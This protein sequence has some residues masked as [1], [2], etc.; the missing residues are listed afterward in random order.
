MPMKGSGKATEFREIDRRDD[1][2]GWI[3]FP[4]ETMQRA[5]HAFAIDGDVWV[6]DP[7]DVE[8]LD[9]LLAEF[10][11]VAGV[12]ILL[13]RHKRDAATVANRHGVA[14]HVPDWMD[15]VVDEID[16]P[17]ERIH[18][19][20][21]D[22]GV[23]VHKLV[24]NRFWQEAA[25]YIEDRDE[26]IVPESV[27]TADYFLVGSERLGVHPMLRMKP[28]K[29][30][31]R[32]SPDRVLVGH[33]AGIHDDASKALSDAVAGARARTPGL[34]LKNLRKLVLG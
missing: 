7:I 32:F 24:D 6:C 3:A 26:L 31:R 21:A 30:L 1:G 11:D 9:D 23:G 25:L 20:L 8:G 19:E 12:V 22:T 15:G 28:P 16:A 17:A 13:D 4:D 2:V 34:Y 14:V 33:G 10:G 29:K 27:G 18:L 5:S